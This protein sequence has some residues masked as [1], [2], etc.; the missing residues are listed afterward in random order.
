[1]LGKHS[2]RAALRQR[3]Q[4]MGYPLDAHELE[5]VYKLFTDLCDRKKEVFDEDLL[6]LLQDGFAEIP[7]AWEMQALQVSSGTTS[8]A[9]ALGDPG[10]RGREPDRDAAS[11]DGPG[12]RACARPSTRSPDSA[13]PCPTSACA[14]SPAAPTPWGE[15]HIHTHF[16]GMKFT[17]RAVS[18]DIL[19][20]SA[21]AYLHASNKAFHAISHRTEAATGLSQESPCEP[22]S[23]SSP[24]TASDRKWSGEAVRALRHQLVRRPSTTT[25]SSRRTLIG[26]A[27]IDVFGSAL[28]PG[29]L[30]ACRTASAVLLGAV[31]ESP[32][33]DHLPPEEKVETGLLRLRSELGLFANLR[34]TRLHARPAARRAREG[35]PSP[36]AR[37]S[38]WCGSWRAACTTASPCMLDSLPRGPTPWPTRPGR[39]SASPGWPSS[40]PGPGGARSPAWTRPMSWRPASSGAP[41]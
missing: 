19:E 17:G 15:A 25:S 23:S 34:P 38:S 1:M 29:T 39:W 6:A 30:E 4:E 2:G 18:T 40:W 32:A 27:A 22:A 41:W 37:T 10:A 21:R 13:G 26:A 16:E 7:D 24:G 8:V 31:G 3:F 5:T 36:R 14:R 33:N 9:T 11:G 35:S 20:A 28:P 12:P